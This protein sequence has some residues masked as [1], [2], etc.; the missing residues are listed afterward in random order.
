MTGPGTDESSSIHI[1]G[2]QTGLLR[3]GHQHDGLYPW[4]RTREPFH[5]LIAEYFLRR[6]TRTAVARVFPQVIERYPTLDDLAQADP[7]ELCVIAKELGL[8]Q[9]TAQLPQ[10]ARV[11]MEK[12]GLSNNR[13]SLLGVPSIGPYITDAIFLYAYGSPTFPLDSSVQRVLVRAAIG[14]DPKKNSN[15]YK[16]KVLLGVVTTLTIGLNSAELRTL[17]QGVLYIAWEFCRPKPLCHKCP[18]K[19]NC[20]YG[21]DY[22]SN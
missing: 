9:R 12:G 5:L 21:Q 22:C 19:P 15:P 7:E 13:E 8:R 3:Q 18:V 2:L 1:E 4:H 20:K 10:V 14:V 6:T 16:D 17:H 11:V